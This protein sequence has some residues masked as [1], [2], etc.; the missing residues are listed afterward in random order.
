MHLLVNVMLPA[1]L[2]TQIGH[3]GYVREGRDLTLKYLVPYNEA[4]PVIESPWRKMGIWP[5]KAYAI[6]EV[7]KFLT[8]VA[9]SSVNPL[10]I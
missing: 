2:H 3:V 10:Y 5:I 8:I 7:I 6:C 9:L 4:D 1:P